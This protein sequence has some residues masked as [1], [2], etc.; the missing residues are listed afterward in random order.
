MENS[1]RD[2]AKAVLA[3]IM[4]NI[5]YSLRQPKD[6]NML[7]KSFT[8]EIEE[9]HLMLLDNVN[10]RHQTAARI[11]IFIGCNN[12]CILINSC[13][14]LFQNAKSDDQLA[15]LVRILTNELIDKTL[16]PYCDK[17]GY[18]SCVLEDIF[19]KNSQNINDLQDGNGN[20]IGI[21]QMWSNL[22]T[23]LK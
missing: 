8:N 20:V 23:L 9:I 2:N 3:K 1:I 14:Y 21:V 19:S 13:K 4:F 16:Q 7:L 12:P 17:G 18:F 15:L 10:I 5:D 11:I 6:N 22:L